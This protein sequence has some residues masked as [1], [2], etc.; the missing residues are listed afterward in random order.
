MSV[1][2]AAPATDQADPMRR[3][4]PGLDGVRGLAILMVMLSHFIVVGKNLELHNPLNRLLK[5]GYLGVDFFFVLSGFLITGIL[6]DSKNRKPYFQVF[7]WRRALRIFP[8]YYGVLAIS[9]L[10]VLWITPGDRAQLTGA[11]SPA[12]FWL[13]ASNIGMAC[14]GTWLECPTWV[15][16]GHFWSLAVEEQFY[17]V[18]PLL[19][20]FLPVKWLERLC[21]L[22]VAASPFVYHPLSQWIGE[23]PAYASTLSRLGV[24]AAGGWLAVLWRKEQLWSRLSPYLTAT[25]WCSG[26]LLLLERSVL[27]QLSSVEPT[28]VLIFGSAL[29]AVAVNGTG[30]LSGPFF[31]SAILRWFGKYSYGIYVYHHALKPVWIYFLWEK[32]I[33]PWVGAGM[34][35]TLLYT[36]VATA[37]SLMLAWL[38]WRFFEAPLL[39][40]KSRV[41]FRPDKS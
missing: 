41:G 38:S 11:D 40:Y 1:A 32:S 24:L 12:W 17:L 9:W 16:L 39:S 36:A 13:Y 37:L 6:I 23:V 3:H 19:V 15:G 10:T 21:I 2:N 35:G 34:S 8:L 33:V 27:P 20:Y 5:S 29:V 4:I 26:L 28:I 7:Y 30:R 22:L 14:K 18:W 31:S 25:L